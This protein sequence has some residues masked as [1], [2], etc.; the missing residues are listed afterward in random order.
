MNDADLECGLIDVKF[1]RWNS[2]SVRFYWFPSYCCVFV[3]TV[4]VF[5]SPPPLVIPS[6][7]ALSA[8]CVL[9]DSR[10]PAESDGKSSSPIP[11]F[12]QF[13]RQDE[14]AIAV[15]N[16]Q[17]T[18]HFPHLD[19]GIIRHISVR[20]TQRCLAGIWSSIPATIRV[21]FIFLSYGMFV[22]GFK[23]FYLFRESWVEFSILDYF[24]LYSFQTWKNV[25]CKFSTVEMWQKW[26]WK[27]GYLFSFL[28]FNWKIYKFRRIKVYKTDLFS[29]FLSCLLRPNRQHN[30]MIGDWTW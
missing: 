23:T 20:R 15:W 26:C 18:V 30:P 12:V 21:T 24:G 14:K 4:A 10:R 5:L 7:C 6:V 17:T 28:F 3:A 19:A 8:G 11:R 25:R 16:P 29:Y 13:V 22:C 2:W 27:V 9:L 1:S